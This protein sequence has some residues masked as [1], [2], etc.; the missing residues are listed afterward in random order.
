VIPLAYRERMRGEPRP[1]W[2]TRGFVAAMILLAAVPLLYPALPP[3]VDLPGHMARYR[4][5]LDGGHSPFLR[6]YYSFR[7]A[8]MGNLGVDLLVWPLGKLMGL[9]PAVKLIVICIPVL[10]VAGMLWVAREVHGRLPPTAALALPFAYGHHFQFGFVNYALSAALAML[11]FGLWLR[12]GRTGHV[13]L[14]AVLFMPIGLLVWVCHVFGWGLLGLLAFSSDAVRQ[15]DG[16]RSWWRAALQS[17]MHASVLALP[18]IPMLL[19]RENGA[20]V[21]FGWFK[22][23]RKLYWV[24]MAL[25]DRWMVADIAAVLVPAAVMLFVA[26]HRSVTFSR[27]LTFTGLVL[28]AAFLLLP[29]TI[30]GSA[31]ADMRLAPFTWAMFLL[32]MRFRDSVDLRL[33]TRLA[34][35]S[36]GL[37]L[38][39][40]LVL[41]TS[42]WIAADDQNA[43]LHALDHVP[44]GARVL[45]LVGEG[46][47][48]KGR[49]ALPRNS[50]LG[51]LTV[52][53]REGFSNNHWEIPGARLMTV[54]YAPAGRF[55][56]DPSQVTVPAQCKGKKQSMN[57]AL[58]SFPRAAFDYVWLLDPG[59]F[60]P[61]LLSDAAPV[62]R[63]PGTVLYRLPQAPPMPTVGP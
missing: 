29:W 43:K 50:H 53:R 47:G 25:R 35:V 48:W 2:E 7:W 20:G 62:F 14:R 45:S 13:R 6:Q 17:A 34:W 42:L 54:V 21:T 15:H 28:T 60:D 39:R 55:R 5:E 63:A 1:W 37:L 31:Y 22:L 23:D 30:F 19:W 57:V 59:P 12:L 52:V 41:T 40:T 49:W 16:G 33:A 11:A 38:A 51:G 26:W 18:L 56:Y 8:L 9:E 36:V 10:T 32:A 44:R 4:V 46:C 61:R 24:F 3:L 58:D 27:M